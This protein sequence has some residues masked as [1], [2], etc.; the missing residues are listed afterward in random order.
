[1][2]KLRSIGFTVLVSLTLYATFFAWNVVQMSLIPA[3]V[4]AAHDR[5]ERL[6]ACQI[7]G[8][9]L[10]SH[11]L[12]WILWAAGAAIVFWWFTRTERKEPVA[13]LVFCGFAAPL[14][15]TSALLIVPLAL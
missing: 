3:A 5:G 4:Q 6:P 11:R 7:L 13:L 8:V 14:V 2:R 15:A 12:G 9:D 1:M 10:A